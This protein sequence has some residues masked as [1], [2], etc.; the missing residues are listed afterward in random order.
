M[1]SVVVHHVCCVLW[2]GMLCAQIKEKL[3]AE[4]VYDIFRHITERDCKAL[5]FNPRFSRPEN[6]IMTVRALGCGSPYVTA[7]H[8]HLRAVTPVLEH[9]RIW[10]HVPPPTVASFACG[11]LFLVWYFSDPIP[12]THAS[13]FASPLVL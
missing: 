8:T 13:L 1:C 12:C 9:A 2:C 3:R 6:L 11:M 4:R 10:R 5:G 7:S